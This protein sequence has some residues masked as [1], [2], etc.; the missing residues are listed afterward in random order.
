MGALL[1]GVTSLGVLLT[2]LATAGCSATETDLTDPPSEIRLGV[3]APLT[4]PNAELG[5]DQV[6]GAK[7]AAQLVN[8]DLDEDITAPLAAGAGLPGLDGA[9][10]KIV[11]SDSKSDPGTAAQAAAQL[12]REERTHGLVAGGDDALTAAVSQ[13][14]EMLRIPLV[15]G[16]NSADYLT[17]LGHDWF[18]RT[19]PTSRKIGEMLLS[20]LGRQRSKGQPTRRIAVLHAADSHGEQVA[21]TMEGLAAD[22]GYHLVADVAFPPGASNLSRKVRRLQSAD[23]EVLLTSASTADDALTLTRALDGARQ[24]VLTWG[25][26]FDSPGFAKAVGSAADDMFRAATWSTDLADRHPAARR[27]AELYSQRNDAPMTD[28]AAGAFTAVLTL[29]MAV[30]DAGSARPHQMRSALI[31]MRLP[32]KYTIMPWDGIQFGADGQNAGCAGIVEQ[33]HGDQPRVVYPRELAR[34]EVAWPGSK[35]A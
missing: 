11:V 20:F 5:R 34:V 6:R 29:A 21:R 12:V 18:F 30:D 22:A 27:V 19:A 14:S 26:G 23:P 13:R 4:G 15:D 10:V 3:I 17:Q 7:L 32:G 16:H 9:T 33:W 35:A 31:A 24:P 2:L 1:R 25:P 28:I 8:D